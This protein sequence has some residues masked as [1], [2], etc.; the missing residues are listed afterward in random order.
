MF[1]LPF[2][3][4]GKDWK[5]RFF[6]C[7]GVNLRQICV[8]TRTTYPLNQRFS[9]D[10]LVESWMQI[11]DSEGFLDSTGVGW[12]SVRTRIPYQDLHTL[13]P[14]TNIHICIY[15]YNYI[16]ICFKIML[17]NQYPKMSITHCKYHEHD[18]KGGSWGGTIC[19]YIYNN[20]W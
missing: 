8:C 16:Y 1:S 14:K 3:V 15:I 5:L 4:W 9:Q 17:R 2:Q 13:S 20:Q 6:A 18:M 19:I 11:L 12:L 7:K 10:S